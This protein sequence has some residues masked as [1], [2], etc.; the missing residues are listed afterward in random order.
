MEQVAFDLENYAIGQTEMT[1]Y[2]S[3]VNAGPT[4][5]ATITSSD[6]DVEQVVLTNQG[7]GYMVGT[8][9]LGPAAATSGD[10]QIGLVSETTTMTVRFG[11]AS[12]TATAEAEI[13]VIE[14]S[15]G[16]DVIVVDIGETV[17]INVNGEVFEVDPSRV[18][19]LDFNAKSGTD[20]ITING[21]VANE[22]ATL[23]EYFVKVEGFFNFTALSVENV[24][25]NSGGGF[26]TASLY[27][28]DRDD[29]V[30]VN[31][32]SI[33]YTGQQFENVVNDYGRLLAFA[34]PGGLDRV[35]FNDTAGS[36]R[37]YGTPIYANMQ[38]ATTFVNAR[39]F[40][41]VMAHATEGGFDY[42]TFIGTENSDELFASPTLA[43][44]KGE[45]YQLNASGFERTSIDGRGGDDSANLMGSEAND[46]FFATPFFSYLYGEGYFNH[47]LRFENV[48]A[49][50]AGGSDRANMFDSPGTDTYRGTPDFSA[51]FSN[52]YRNQA[53]GFDRVSAFGSAGDNN[54]VLIDSAGND[55]F[56]GREK[57]AYMIGDNFLNYVN[58]FDSV[59]A[60]ANGGNDT[61]ILHDSIEDNRFFGSS[62][63]SSLSGNTFFNRAEGFDRVTA[64]FTKG[65]DRARFED[66]TGNDTFVGKGQDQTL[67][68]TGYFI[69]TKGLDVVTAVSNQ[70]G[71][72]VLGKPQIEFDLIEVGNWNM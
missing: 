44:M 23:G 38:T 63:Y 21:S 14:G 37:F 30:V 19:S 42:A 58:G 1:I 59:T 70:G 27:G 50:S 6:G 26:D 11:S 3:D 7:G 53:N 48:T 25:L 61:A 65:V 72:D 28:T 46:V 41:Q 31:G 10:G 17:V 39:G 51:L 43:N 35:T 33:T 64:F 55:R 5:T 40:D 9:A 20:T 36:D 56:V 60:I 32:D 34:T 29:V 68:G 52:Q 12:D 4:R 54:A 45:D 66:S 16:N 62:L 22:T 49:H 47:V 18:G 8:L 69:H 67:F 71:T 57:D 13:L 24:T 2:A 15:T